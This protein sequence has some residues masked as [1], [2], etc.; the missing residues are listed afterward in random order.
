M[1]WIS[2][3]RRSPKKE[4]TQLALYL[5][6]YI[7]LVLLPSICFCSWGGAAAS[8]EGVSGSCPWTCTAGWVCK[9]KEHEN[10]ITVRSLIWTETGR[11]DWYCVHT[12]WRA[13]GC[14]TW[15]LGLR[16][17]VAY[18]YG[19]ILRGPGTPIEG[20]GAIF[21]DEA[22]WSRINNLDLLITFL[23]YVVSL[24]VKEWMIWW[25]FGERTSG[26]LGAAVRSHLSQV[27]TRSRLPQRTG[28]PLETP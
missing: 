16:T 26:T 6:Y 20:R 10:V 13:I 1:A 18:L 17:P 14:T 12:C 23:K 27:G 7:I 4:W 2:G 8:M 5:I 11:L 22:G 25:W 9:G 19:G 15:G 24:E 21:W 28:Y 3:K